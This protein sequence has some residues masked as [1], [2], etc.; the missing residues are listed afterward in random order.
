MIFQIVFSA[1][2]RKK[3][4]SYDLL[5]FRICKSVS[6][7]AKF[8]FQKNQFAKLTL[9]PEYALIYWGFIIPIIAKFSREES[10]K[11]KINYYLYV[12]AVGSYNDFIIRLKDIEKFCDIANFE[13]LNK[14]YKYYYIITGTPSEDISQRL[15]SLRG[16]R[17]KG[18]RELY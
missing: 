14:G 15:F 6:A 2:I 1:K 7:L 3:R 9:P 12:I 4:C 8:I 11:L 5:I 17:F 13:F 16:L 18:T 10:S